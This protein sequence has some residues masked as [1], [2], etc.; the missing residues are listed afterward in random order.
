M[1]V[2]MLDEGVGLG[3]LV[4]S[5]L[6]DAGH[7]VVRCHPW[8]QPVFPCV[9]LLD[10]ELCP[11][12]H[13]SVGV[14]VKISGAKTS[15]PGHHEEGVVCSLRHRVPLVLAGTSPDPS[16]VAV[17]AAISPGHENVVHVVEQVVDADVSDLSVAA[18]AT[19]LG[20]LEGHDLPHVDVI[21]RVVRRDNGLVARLEADDDLPAAISEVVA[22]KVHAALKRGAPDVRSISVSV[23]PTG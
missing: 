20:V 23:V 8:G 9:G 1:R 2:L 18:R 11:L 21:A 22:I 16:L 15:C 4:E 17:A 3:G 5:D 19:A 10:R 14:A 6:V 12:E 7:E 13:A